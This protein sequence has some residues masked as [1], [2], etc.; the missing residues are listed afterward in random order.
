MCGLCS[1]RCPGEQVQYHV[2]ILSRRLYGKYLAPWPAHVDEA[3]TAAKEGRFEHNLRELMKKGA[4]E[5]KKLYT[6]RTVEP[7]MADEFWKPP[8]RED[9]LKVV[10]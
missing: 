6:E 10:S 4:N 7:D 3:V 2:S 1:A 9:L 8:K 5:L